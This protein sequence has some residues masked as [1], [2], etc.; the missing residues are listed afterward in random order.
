MCFWATTELGKSQALLSRKLGLTPSAISH[1]VAR[2]R[3]ISAENETGVD[4]GLV[5]M[6]L[7][8]SPEE[9][10]AANDRMASTI[11]ELRDA[12]GQTKAEAVGS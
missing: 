7:G 9:R 2:G 5:A 11:L 1:A 4:K 3:K 6:F 10:L 8:M 12:Y